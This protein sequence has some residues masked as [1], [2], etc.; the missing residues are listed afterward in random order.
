MLLVTIAAANHDSRLTIDD[1][2]PATRNRQPPLYGKI[3]V[4]ASY[5]QTCAKYTS[6]DLLH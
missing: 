2:Q 4:A 1:L 5:L 6:M 3:I